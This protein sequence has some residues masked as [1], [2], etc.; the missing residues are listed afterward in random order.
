MSFTNSRLARNVNMCGV[1][2]SVT[3]NIYIYQLKS[4]FLVTD[5]ETG[6]LCQLLK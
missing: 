3:I 5:D 2:S 6:A 1:A 4:N